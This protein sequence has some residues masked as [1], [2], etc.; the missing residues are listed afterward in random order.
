MAFTRLGHVVPDTTPFMVQ[1]ME[2]ATRAFQRNHGWRY[3]ACATVG[4]C[5]AAGCSSPTAPNPGLDFTVTR[6]T[7][8]YPAP[9]PD[10]ATAPGSVVVKGVV[11]TS[12]PCYELSATSSS[13]ATTLTIRVIA[14]S[15]L[16]AGSSCA[17]ALQTFSYTAV[18]RVAPGA[19]EVVVIHSNTSGSAETVVLDKSVT[20]PAD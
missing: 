16:Q 3:T 17:Q 18:S 19:V 11:F 13:S 7:A 14:R 5:L 2:I 6:T 20:V 1:R 15:T 4:L 10:V 8:S 12:T 9:A